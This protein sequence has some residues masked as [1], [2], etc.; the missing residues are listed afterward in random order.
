MVDKFA[1]SHRRCVIEGVALAHVQLRRLQ[2]IPVGAELQLLRGRVTGHYRPRATKAGQLERALT[3]RQRS[4]V[5]PVAGLQLGM[6]LGGGIQQPRQGRMHLRPR[7]EVDH[8][9]NG[10]GTIAYPAEAAGPAR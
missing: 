7:H 4:S 9:V 10:K 5:E 1:D 2:Q 3:T 8:R 6:S